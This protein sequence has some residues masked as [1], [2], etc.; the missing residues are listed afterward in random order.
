M[1]SRVAPSGSINS[2]GSPASRWMKKISVIVPRI[3]T[4]DWIRRLSRKRVIEA[5]SIPPERASVF[6]PDPVDEEALVWRRRPAQLLAGAV[7]DRDLIE[8]NERDGRLCDLV[9]AT[10][11]RE[12]RRG[13]EQRAP[14]LKLLVH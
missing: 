6:P 3:A 12:P 5:I 4:A 13:I 11:M 2:V 14:G 8:R 1:S 10:I 9:H 7:Q